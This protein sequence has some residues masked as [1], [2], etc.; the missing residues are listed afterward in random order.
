MR[1]IL[2]EV[3]TCCNSF[4]ASPREKFQFLDVCCCPGGFSAYTLDAQPAARGIG[5][6][7]PPDLGGHIPAIEQE[8]SRCVTA[9]QLQQATRLM[10]PC[11]VDC[12]H[13]PGCAVV[14]GEEA[15]CCKSSNSRG[16]ARTLTLC[17]S[18]LQVL[19]APGGCDHCGSQ[20]A[21]GGLMARQCTHEVTAVDQ[22][23]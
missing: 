6:S 22:C 7:L 9:A 15:T 3:D 21:C 13:A 8:T 16:H 5:L 20:C 1:T 2:T 19:H 11:G 18:W 10:S 23:R 4:I 17:S 14:R 12:L